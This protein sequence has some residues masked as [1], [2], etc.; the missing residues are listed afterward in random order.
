MTA[1]PAHPD[2][3]RNDRAEDDGQE[4]TPGERVAIE[5]RTYELIAERLADATQF[6][7]LMSGIEPTMELYPHLQRIVA[8]MMRGDWNAITVDA[9]VAACRNITRRI[10]QEA[11]EV[12]GAECEA[13]ATMEV[14]P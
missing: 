11:N 8:N 5:V 6:A 9:V 7:D 14:A 10:E 12:W 1:H 2:A 13:I 4:I 3:G